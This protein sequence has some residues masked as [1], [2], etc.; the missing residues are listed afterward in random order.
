MLRVHHHPQHTVTDHT[1]VPRL[2][3]SWPYPLRR[4]PSFVVGALLLLSALALLVHAL[5][6]QQPRSVL[7][8]PLLR[9]QQL[10]PSS[11]EVDAVHIALA[12]AGITVSEQALIHELPVDRRR[13]VYGRLGLIVRWGDP[14]R[15]FVGDMTHRIVWPIVGYGV[16]VP[17]NT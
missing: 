6:P 13:P 15:A 9:Y 2:P 3:R 1:G 11:C 10:Y 16:Y 7:L 12:M 5:L 14:N 8:A 4:R 17:P